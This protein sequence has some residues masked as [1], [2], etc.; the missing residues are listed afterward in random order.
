MSTYA[1][2]PWQTAMSQA[3]VSSINQ[4]A[5]KAGLSVETVR[6]IVQ[7]TRKAPQEA[8][9]RRL[10]KALHKGPSEVGKWVGLSLQEDE[11]P[12]TPPKEASLLTL[13][14]RAAVDEMIKLLALNR[15]GATQTTEP[16]TMPYLLPREVYGGTPPPD[17]DDYGVYA[18]RGDVEAEQ[19]AS[20]ELP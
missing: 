20:Q 17:P 7:G 5:R 10:A 2:E 8:T 19:E 18:Q 1:V 6:R 16:V 14:E 12:Y 11:A 9:I 3:G 13:R 4:L 15:M